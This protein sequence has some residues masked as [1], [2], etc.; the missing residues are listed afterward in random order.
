[1]A[2]KK[3]V[4]KIN[5]STNLIDA[6][7]LL[8]G[9]SSTALWISWLLIA[10]TSPSETTDKLLALSVGL[11][12]FIAGL[13]LL[14]TRVSSY[15]VNLFSIVAIATLFIGIAILE[16]KDMSKEHPMGFGTNVA[17]LTLIL[18]ALIPQLLQQLNKN[19][20]ALKIILWMP[21]IFVT[22]FVGLAFFQTRTTLLEPGHS[23]YVLNEMMAP[24][25][26]NNP[27]QEFV[28]QYAFLASWLVVPIY[29]LFDVVTATDLLVIIFCIGGFASLL[30]SLYL[31][32]K[33]F[34]KVTF[35]F[36]LIFI[37]PFSTP[38][39]GW[40]RLSFIGPASTLLSGPALRIL[41]GMLVG[42]FGVVVAARLWA[43]KSKNWETFAVG[44]LSA[45]V[46]W[47]NFDFGAAALLAI[48][49]T[50]FF[51][52]IFLKEQFVKKFFHLLLGIISGWVGVYFALI[53]LGGAPN[54]NL[55]AWFARQF[56]GGFGSVT[57]EIPGPVLMAF[58]VIM[59]TATF[60]IYAIY[61][62]K[63][64]L[65]ENSNIWAPLVAAYFG[66]WSTFS[67][68]Y[69]INRSYHAGQMSMLYVPL[70]LALFAAV[71]I[72]W[73]SINFKFEWR[74]TTHIFLALVTAFP[75]ATVLLIP[76][77]SIEWKRLHGGN[78]DS[79]FPRAPMQQAI[80]AYPAVEKLA[81]E[82]KLTLGYF[83]EGGNY[84]Q[85]LTGAKSVN[86][87]NSPL[88]MFQSDA[89]VKLS[90]EHLIKNG[91]QILLLTESAKMTF[92]W[93][94]GSLCDGLYRITAEN[95]NLALRQ[96]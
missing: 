57:I 43:G 23:E 84:V 39:P 2:K 32:K 76:N 37:L 11:T 24:S 51:L 65:N 91:T 19:N 69:Y 6:F 30:I 12:C 93:K 13:R 18:A 52:A 78:P 96:K 47:N 1:M 7:V 45:A 89:S 53:L 68:P 50:Y 60:G 34:P 63:K 58:P 92:A 8:I 87:F 85:M 74:K 3:T 9:L 72:I 71:S 73:G 56:G 49:L 21:A 31:A 80:D 29:K 40:N 67:L 64:D 79:T 95:P 44:A 86:I 15:L 82:Q 66:M 27:Y 10:K 36:A 48:V 38:T 88:D 41:G 17:I 83:G 28:P 25:A 90:C 35:A 54:W 59:S 5:N 14:G 94:D 70:S 22:S 55:F 33:V 46:F 26:G 75:I 20:S 81:N 77:P 42:L 61:K 62:F 4:T 16:H